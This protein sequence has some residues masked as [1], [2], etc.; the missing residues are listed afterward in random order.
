MDG[1]CVTCH[2]STGAGANT[3]VE[4]GLYAPSG[5]NLLGGGFVNHQGETVTSVHNV[6]GSA[7]VSW[8]D[9]RLGNG[10][11]D[12]GECH[13][14]D[15]GLLE[16]VA[17]SGYGDQPGARPVMG[18][19]LACVT[20]HLPHGG[21]NYRMLRVQLSGI[22][23]EEVQ[24]VSNEIGGDAPSQQGY[25]PDYVTARYRT[26]MVDWCVE[27]HYH[28]HET[29]TVVVADPGNKEIV[30]VRYRHEVNAVLGTVTTSLPREQPEGFSVSQQPSDRLLCLTCH[31]AHGTSA[32]ATG[33]AASA[34]PAYDS[35]LL[36]IDD[37]GVCQDCHKK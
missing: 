27:C 18:E 1:L 33:L 30:G 12:C 7:E 6:D 19:P 11:W 37:R 3:N 15:D 4:D 10:N 21:D 36:R 20:C 16:P 29:T 35:A 28:Y 26:G 24:V 22:S 17:D 31:Y 23:S 5:E 13:A 34:A 2:G 8:I 25:E 9:G 14:D 32:T